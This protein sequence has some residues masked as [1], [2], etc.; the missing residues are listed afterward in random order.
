MVTSGSIAE[1]GFGLAGTGFFSSPPDPA[2]GAAVAGLEFVTLL[3]NATDGLEIPVNAGPVDLELSLEP[4]LEDTDSDEE[5]D[6]NHRQPGLPLTFFSGIQPPLV[7]VEAARSFGFSE[8]TNPATGDTVA[9]VAP[10]RGEST[11]ALPE[12]GASS[13]NGEGASTLELAPPVA[14]KLV[15]DATD[16]ANLAPAGDG[17]IDEPPGPGIRAP[18]S[19]VFALTKQPAHAVSE[20]SSVFLDRGGTT[21]SRLDSTA[22]SRDVETRNPAPEAPSEK[23]RTASRTDAGGEQ[24]DSSFA[25][26]DGG[27]SADSEPSTGDHGRH[28][29]TFAMATPVTPHRVAIDDR[30][31]APRPT[32]ATTPVRTIA[33]PEPLA[34]GSVHSFQIKLESARTPEPVQVH[35]RERAGEIRIDVRGPDLGLN[36]ELRQDLP[37]LLRNLEEQGFRSLTWIQASGEPALKAQPADAWAD[38][39]RGTGQRE[40]GEPSDGR[41]E[42]SGQAPG[43]EQQPRHRRERRW[44]RQWMAMTE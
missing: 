7:M 40:S 28:L 11:A 5:P 8:C 38:A 24:Q 20:T 42:P 12:A 35:V 3:L 4:R 31:A 10:P 44:E 34:G 33:D 6:D 14:F 36:Q 26:Q 17:S 9:A 43:D 30:I 25:G 27:A 18:E 2:A 39:N 13:G 32:D 22:S 29:E 15:L 23:T 1:N 37:S 19:S 41:R 16:S 21:V